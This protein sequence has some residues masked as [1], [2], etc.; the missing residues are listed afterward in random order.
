MRFRSLSI[1]AFSFIFAASALAQVSW[2]D[3]PLRNWNT[4]SVVPT[5]PR[6]NIDTRCREQI[7]TPETIAERAVTRAGWNLFGATYTYSPVTIVWGMAAAD[8]QCRPNQYNVFVFVNNRFAGTLSPQ[9]VDSRT[10][11]AFGKIELFKGTA[12]AEFARYT[13]SDALCCPSQTSL[14]SFTI[15]TTATGNV[16]ATDVSTSKNCDT[17]G[18]DMETQDNV[19]SGTVTYRQRSAL[20]TNSVLTVKLVDVSRADAP[21]VTI[22]EQRVET[23]G[24]QV[25][26][27]FDMAYDRSKIQERNRYAVQAEIRDASGRLLFITDTSYPVITQGNPR[28][29]EIVVVPVGGGNPGGP[30]GR[31]NLI[32]GSVSYLQRS[33]LLPNSE[34][35]VRLVDS[36]DPTGAP[37]SE[38]KFSSGTRQVPLQYELSYE[39][40]DINRQRNYEVQAEIRDPNGRLQF[41][42]EAGKTVNLRGN[43]PDNVDLVVVPASD[44]PTPITGRTVNMNR[45]GT[46]SLRIG[47]RSAILLNASVSVDAQGEAR[48]TL[49]GSS[50]TTVFSGKL[51]TYETGR[52]VITV[53]SSGDADASG[54]IQ[55]TF[56]GNS[57]RALSATSLVL[58]GQDVTLRF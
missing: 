26:F 36:G 31:Q 48:V 40:R 39:A 29:V 34:V 25:P 37:V 45:F 27:S 18:G 12:T 20:P 15:P 33:A 4:S 55:V 32:R 2:L 7:R 58:D 17:G 53:E 52:L 6:G 10:D 50:G 19:V 24:K 56:S 28:S 11:G 8:G 57:L 13:S 1:I 30:G 51:T 5:A 47:T 41:K 44:G 43:Q 35:I 21:S 3:Q 23:A 42:T 9:P 54:E 14:V 16:R 38:T 22:N 46:G 49:N